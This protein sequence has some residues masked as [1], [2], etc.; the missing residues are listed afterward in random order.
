MPP[1][2]RWYLSLGVGPRMAFDAAIAAAV[3]AIIVQVVRF[4][5][6]RGVL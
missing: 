6:F 2:T 5:I 1:V 3:V 4:A